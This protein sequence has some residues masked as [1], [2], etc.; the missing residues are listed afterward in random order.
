MTQVER[1]CALGTFSRRRWS[2]TWVAF[3]RTHGVDQRKLNEASQLAVTMEQWQR[4]HGSKV[5][6]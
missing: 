5:P 1:T 2:K 4:E 6:D 3:A